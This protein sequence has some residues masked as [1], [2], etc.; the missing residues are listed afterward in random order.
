MTFVQGSLESPDW[1]KSVEGDLRRGDLGARAASLHGKSTAPLHLQR[2]LSLGARR[3]LLHQRRQRARR[4]Q[5]LD[6]AI[7]QRSGRISR[8]LC[9]AVERRQNQS[10][11]SQSGDAEQ[12][13]WPAQQRHISKKSWRGCAKRVSSMSIAFGSLPPRWF[14]ADFKLESFQPF[15]KFKSFKSFS[16]GSRALTSL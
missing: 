11:R 3:R 7:S 8:P 4:N 12:L 16:D 13:S 15:K 1:L 14:M 5:E 6:G 10:S 2:N 9:Q